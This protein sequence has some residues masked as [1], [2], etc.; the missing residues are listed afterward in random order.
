MTAPVD[1]H[2]N[3]P[4]RVHAQAHAIVLIGSVC[5]LASRIRNLSTARPPSMAFRKRKWGYP[6]AALPTQ[7]PYRRSRCF[8]RT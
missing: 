3:P 1:L 6:A 8:Y 5:I 4:P 7:M 2:L